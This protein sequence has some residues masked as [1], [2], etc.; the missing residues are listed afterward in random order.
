MEG[1]LDWGALLRRRAEPERRRCAACCVRRQRACRLPLTAPP[2]LLPSASAPL[3][4]P[5][6]QEHL[7]LV[8]ELLRANLYEFQK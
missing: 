7:V 4:P 8:T 6:Q 2:N 1:L 5:R 3:H